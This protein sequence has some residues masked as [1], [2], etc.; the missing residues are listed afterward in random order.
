MRLK[1]VPRSG[2]LNRVAAESRPH[3]ARAVPPCRYMSWAMAAAT[4]GA[5][6]L[7]PLHRAHPRKQRLVPFTVS[8]KCVK[9]V[10][11]TS[12]AGA[13]ASTHPPWLENG[14]RPRESSAPTA[15]T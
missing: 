4:F 15:T 11:T 6:K 8:S 12:T 3:A 9:N 10:L 13:Q 2:Y 1:T 7:V 5:A 14:A